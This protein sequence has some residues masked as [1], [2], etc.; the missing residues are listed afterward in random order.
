MSDTQRYFE[1]GDLTYPMVQVDRPTYDELRKRFDDAHGEGG[2][3]SI[4][5]YPVFFVDDEQGLVIWPKPQPGVVV[6]E[7]PAEPQIR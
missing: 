5:G 1:I 3:E 7:R 2:F 6:R 4:V